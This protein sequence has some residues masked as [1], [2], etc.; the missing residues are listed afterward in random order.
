MLDLVIREFFTGFCEE[1]SF[2]FRFPFSFWDGGIAGSIG[3]L[4]FDE[5]G[6]ISAIAGSI[7]VLTFDE[8]GEISALF[9]AE[10]LTLE[11]ESIILKLSINVNY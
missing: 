10:S 6:E 4:T 11:V 1:I 5:D 9:V 3:V 8:D 2:A 7:G